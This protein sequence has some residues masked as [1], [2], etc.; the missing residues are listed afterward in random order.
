MPAS[1]TLESRIRGGLYGVA[2]GDA[3]GATLEFETAES[4]RARWGE[5]REIVGGG[6]LDLPPGAWTDDTEMTLALAEGILDDPA[7]P[8]PHVGRR[9]LAWME[10]GPP[11]IGNT[12][13]AVLRLMA[14]GAFSP[15][16]WHR[17]AEQVHRELRGMTAGN[18]ALMRTLPVGLAYR[19][20][21]DVMARAEELARMT[22]WDPRAAHSC[23][24]ASLT[25]F[26][27]A[28][29][30]AT[31]A[32]ALAWAAELLASRV[33]DAAV[34]ELTGP[35]LRR[36]WGELRPS[37]FTVES[38]HCALWGLLEAPDFEEAVVWVAN[39]GG[40][41]D[42]NAAIAG[43]LAGVRWGFE[44]IPKRWVNALSPEQRGRL[45]RVAEG[46]LALAG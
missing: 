24:L 16:E 13:R 15:R 31:P 7:D 46:L 27:M 30:G 45:D 39:L 4:I 42:T 5:L 3:L 11:D 28:R 9:F 8:L 18:G 17:A 10:S 25:A 44:A 26:G 35:A 23:M 41:A 1:P 37:G 33:G 21:Q 20:P 40:D 2:V 38:L 34:E 43:G 32:D 36:S 19:D 14:R 12:V 22:H 29:S 6:W